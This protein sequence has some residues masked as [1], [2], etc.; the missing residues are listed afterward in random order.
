MLPVTKVKLEIIALGG[1]RYSSNITAWAVPTLPAIRPVQP[2]V[3]KKWQHLEDLPVVHAGPEA[4]SLVMVMDIPVVHRVL[5]SRFGAPHE[6]YGIRTPVGWT[7]MGPIHAD[8]PHAAK[9]IAQ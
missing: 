9:V 3:Y 4:I 2:A 7:I 5:E 6:P 1:S 8:G